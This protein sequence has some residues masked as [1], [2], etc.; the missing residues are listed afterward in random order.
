MFDFGAALYLLKSGHKL[1]R[2]SWLK[3][4][5]VSLGTA[6]V[7]GP[8]IVM[9]MADGSLS[10]WTSSSSDLMASDWQVVNG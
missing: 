4:V 5:F 2:A 6:E 9:N 7:Y 3:G 8:H 1:S 10:P